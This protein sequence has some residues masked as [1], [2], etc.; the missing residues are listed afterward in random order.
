MYGLNEIQIAEVI[1]LVLSSGL[2][3]G[4]FV[5]SLIRGLQFIFYKSL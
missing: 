1:L 4:T 5:G 2:I 3:I